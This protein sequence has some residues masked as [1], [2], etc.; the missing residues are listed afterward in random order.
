M[1]TRL[2]NILIVLSLG[3]L[4]TGYYFKSHR[5]NSSMDRLQHQLKDLSSLLPPTATVYFNCAPE[6]LET[7]MQARYLL[8]PRVLL[9]TKDTTADTL[10]RLL[11]VTSVIAGSN[12]AWQSADDRFHYLLTIKTR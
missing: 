4:L 10:L 11:P 1:N 12:I 7:Y 3:I 6:Y 9:Y 8:A 2:V 5:R